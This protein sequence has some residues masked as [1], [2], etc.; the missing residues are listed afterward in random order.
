MFSERGPFKAR[1]ATCSL[2]VSNMGLRSSILIALALAEGASAFSLVHQPTLFRSPASAVHRSSQKLFR[3]AEKNAGAWARSG[4][5]GLRSSGG[6]IAARAQEVGIMEGSGNVRKVASLGIWASFLAV[7][8]F[9]P[10]VRCPTP[11]ESGE[12]HCHFL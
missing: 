3:T 6:L 2:I 7:A 4:R 8:T 11:R 1:I 9:A 10:D 12:V 5:V